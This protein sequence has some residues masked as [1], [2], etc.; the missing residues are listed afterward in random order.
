M[1]KKKSTG[2]GESSSSCDDSLCQEAKES[3]E[4]EELIVLRK[5]A[6]TQRL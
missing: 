5:G 4:L 6:G 2:I 1:G 3:E